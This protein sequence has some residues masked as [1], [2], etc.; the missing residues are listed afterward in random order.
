MQPRELQRQLLEVATVQ[1]WWVVGRQGRVR[2]RVWYSPLRP[3]VGVFNSRP[4]S[5]EDAADASASDSERGLLCFSVQCICMWVLSAYFPLLLQVCQIAMLDITIIY[6]FD[7]I[8]VCSRDL[9]KKMS[10]T[11]CCNEQRNPR[12]STTVSEKEGKERLLLDT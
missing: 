6:S 1:L 11:L 2:G 7:L 8:H 3:L 5:P 4:C 12:P 10:D 9:L